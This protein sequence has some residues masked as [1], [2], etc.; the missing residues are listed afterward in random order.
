MCFYKDIKSKNKMIAR[1]P[2]RIPN[3]SMQQVIYIDVETTDL[4]CKY[5]QTFPWIIEFGATTQ[6]GNTFKS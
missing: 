2:I 3:P 6:D 4:I 5:E 1:G